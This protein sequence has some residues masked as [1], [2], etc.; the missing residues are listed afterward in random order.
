MQIPLD[1]KAV[2]DEATDIE[3]ARQVSVY[4]SLLIDE[5][6]PNDLQAFARSCFATELA[7]VKVSISY[8]PSM[9]T[10]ASPEADAAV[11]VA[12]L[13]DEVSSVAAELRAAGI[14]TMVITTLPELVQA[15][16]QTSSA[17]EDAVVKQ[18][19]QPV[20]FTQKER[21]E[22]GEAMSTNEISANGDQVDA[23]VA[24]PKKEGDQA[25]D[26]CYFFGIP[27]GDLLY[28]HPPQY[29]ADDGSTIQP[30]EE[31]WELTELAADQLR[32]KMGQWMLATCKE[33]RLALAIAFSFM[34]KPMA[35]DA[36]QATAVQ[37][38]GVGLVAFIPGADMP[39]M[40]LNQV[41]MLLQIAAAYGQPL[42]MQR[43][44]ELAV[45]VGGGFAFRALARQLLAF[46]PALGWAIKAAIGY[47][48]TLAMG[49]AAV[50]Y[51]EADGKI[52]RLAAV[53]IKARDRVMLAA[54]Q[55]K[56]ATSV[57]EALSGAGKAL[58]GKIQKP[59]KSGQDNVSAAVRGVAHAVLE[60][61][62]GAA[63]ADRFEPVAEK[64][65]KKASH[66]LSNVLT[67]RFT[68]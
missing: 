35:L 6:A 10:V 3:A 51:F 54:I 21:A 55:A 9:P 61:S 43:A 65:I 16:A 57:S 39:I 18:T 38:A 66:V 56:D 41:K 63:T 27:E 34:R 68:K 2:F 28:P 12:G 44:K 67:Y 11:V 47:T 50:E 58:T 40:T 52:D 60:K 22:T 7:N 1:L 32:L 5:T 42:G 19:G 53:A 26:P 59:V 25:S 8:F 64:G 23:N 37:N 30:A 14:P 29:L 62:V 24:I 15:I 36:V 48:G 31:P 13:A 4:V 17:A 20:Q 45:V 49:R 33:K 46:V